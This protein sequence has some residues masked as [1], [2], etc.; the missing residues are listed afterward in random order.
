[1][2]QARKTVW[3]TFA[4]TTHSRTRLSVL[5]RFGS[6]LPDGK[7]LR[8]ILWFG[9]MYLILPSIYLSPHSIEHTARCLFMANTPFYF[10]TF[11]RSIRP[12]SYVGAKKKNQNRDF[13]EVIERQWYS[14]WRFKVIQE[15]YSCWFPVLWAAKNYLSDG[16]KAR[17]Y[18]F[19]RESFP[20]NVGKDWK[21]YDKYK[22]AKPRSLPRRP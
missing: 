16:P 20:M 4:K 2:K 21:E 6:A 13:T 18:D 12:A 22:K 9:Y 8:S 1:M 17:I 10:I 15:P 11:D 5:H 14:A 3:S 19:M 7:L